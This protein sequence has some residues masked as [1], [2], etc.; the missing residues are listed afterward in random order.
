M[1]ERIKGGR[2]IKKEKLEEK[3]GESVKTKRRR[4][5]VLRKCSIEGRD[6]SGS[7][8]SSCSCSWFVVPFVILLRVWSLRWLR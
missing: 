7:F 8:V 3:K 4:R 2:E 6:H 1:L 5:G